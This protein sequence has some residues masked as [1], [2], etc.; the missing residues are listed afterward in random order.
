[1]QWTREWW[2]MNILKADTLR[3]KKFP[4][5]TNSWLHW[6]FS[7]CTFHRR[8]LIDR[9]ALYSPPQTW[10][11]PESK[12]ESDWKV[13]FFERSYTVCFS[14]DKDAKGMKNVLRVPKFLKI[15]FSKRS[16]TWFAPPGTP[17]GQKILSVWLSHKKN[18]KN[19]SF[20]ESG[21]GHPRC[22]QHIIWLFGSS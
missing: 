14:S 21:R 4:K 8:G 18:T 6:G 19:A 12:Q 17:E 5:K 1:M 10:R 7:N 15:I 22:Y 2:S 11:N 20:F 9:G 13:A 16:E 3:S